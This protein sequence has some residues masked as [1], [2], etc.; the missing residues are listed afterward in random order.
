MNDYLYFVDEFRS[1]AFAAANY[2]VD[3]N[4]GTFVSISLQEISASHL[5]ERERTD[6]SLSLDDVLLAFVVIDFE[7]DIQAYFSFVFDD[8]P[9]LQ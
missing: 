4:K 5:T 9:E 8:V 2:F 3:E 6:F 1:T 7:G